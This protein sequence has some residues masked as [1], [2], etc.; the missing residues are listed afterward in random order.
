LTNLSR[1]TPML[2]DAGFQ[3]ALERAAERNAPGMH[4]RMP[5]G[6]GHDAQIFAEKLP[7][8]MLFVPSIG[9]I[10][11]HHAENTRDDDLVL[12]CQVLADAAAE[13]LGG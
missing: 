3:D 12:G 8:A 1:S 4:I 11:H 5:S 2:M 6:A 7:A 10:S 9:G 13:I